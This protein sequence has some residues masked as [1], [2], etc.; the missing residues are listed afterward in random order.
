MGKFAAQD[1]EKIHLE[2]RATYLKSAIRVISGY[3]FFTSK[4]LVF[5][6]G[7]SALA[8]AV[9]GT[10]FDSDILFSI[11]IEDIAAVS[12]GKHGLARKAVVATRGGDEYDIQFDPHAKWYESIR[13]LVA[14]IHPRSADGQAVVHADAEDD[15]T[16][17]YYETDGTRTGPV[18]GA[19]IRQ[20]V[21]NN[22]TVYRF[23]KVWRDGMQ[24]WKKAED[25][26]L[27]AC[28]TGPPPLVGDSVNNTL[29]WVLAFAPIIGAFIEEFMAGLFDANPDKLWIITLGL[30][31]VLSL[32]DER[33]LNASGHNTR[34]LGLGQAWLVPVYLYKR[35]KALNQ[36]LAYF[37]VWLVTFFLSLLF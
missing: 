12:E 32:L 18:S 5:A 19:K 34:A 7:G 2:G 20:F 33:K 37:I 1:D 36:N 6:G 27:G 16:Q 17:W 4:R 8:S 22:H 21:K 29:V 24:E 11:P 3:A 28:F 30:N 25:T 15:G 13:D 35:A 31:I 23:T 14:G 26:E 10:P 9:S